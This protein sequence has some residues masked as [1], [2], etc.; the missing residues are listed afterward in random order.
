MDPLSYT[1]LF[2]PSAEVDPAMGSSIAAILAAQQPMPQPAAPAAPGGAAGAPPLSLADLF[3]PPPMPSF[4]TPPTP[5]ASLGDLPPAAQESAR[6][7]ALLALGAGV[8]S[9]KPGYLG[10]GLAQGALAGTEYNRQAVQDY[11]KTQEQQYRNALLVAEQQAK[12]G[13]YSAGVERQK[14]DAENRLA[15]YQAILAHSGGKDKTAEELARSYATG[16]DLQGLYKLAGAMPARKSALDAGIN[17]D[18]PVAM[19]TWAR[20]MEDAQA[21][22]DEIIKAK[23]PEL[24][25]AQLAMEQ[26]KG[27]VRTRQAV[28]EYHILTPEAVARSAA[29]ARAREQYAPDRWQIV[30][31]RGVAILKTDPSVTMPLKDLPDRQ[32]PPISGTEMAKL[33]EQQAQAQYRAWKAE[34]ASEDYKGVKVPDGQLLESARNM[35]VRGGPLLPP[36][37]QPAQA[38]LEK[39][40]A[41]PVLRSEA[42]APAIPTPPHT[43][44]PAVRKPTLADASAAA[45]VHLNPGTIS[46]AVDGIRAEG[47]QATY[48]KMISAGAPPAL[49][50]RYLEIAKAYAQ[51]Q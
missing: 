5:A 36:G 44:P 31:E 9:A 14:H 30:P 2:D 45:Q 12:V 15:M 29:E 8:G 6:R 43:Q 40:A 1:S 22:A 16:G 21:L 35:F 42:T 39:A 17:P 20:K 48:R 10:E 50:S 49:A 24:Q 19:K 33:G 23:N 38:P 3:H 7:Q 11:Q 25:A 41:Q 28:T 51:V 26:A 4:P 37:T 34:Q 47:E 27:D 46:K 13:E 18:D 32:A